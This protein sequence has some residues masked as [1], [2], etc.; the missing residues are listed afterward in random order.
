MV[1]DVVHVPDMMDD[2]MDMTD[3]VDVMDHVPPMVIA[4]V[5]RH[6]CE[7]P[8]PARHDIRLGR[9]GNRRRRRG[10]WRGRRWRRLVGAGAQRSSKERDQ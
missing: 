3:V 9:L 1:P 6:V 8:R 7:P 4:M 10:R 5:A 2:V